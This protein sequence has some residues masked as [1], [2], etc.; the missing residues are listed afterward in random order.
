MAAGA[1]ESRKPTWRSESEGKSRFL[2]VPNVKRNLAMLALR[3]GTPEWESRNNVRSR[4]R[5]AQRKEQKQLACMEI[6]IVEVLVG[7]RLAF[8]GFLAFKF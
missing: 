8:M 1:V 7:G 2:D 3:L 6:R 4:G 5:G